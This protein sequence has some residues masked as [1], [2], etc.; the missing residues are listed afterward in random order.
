LPP[1]TTTTLQI[2]PASAHS[3]LPP[4]STISV[5][6]V[7]QDNGNESEGPVLVS[8]QVI[9]KSSE[10]GRSR[11]QTTP[12]LS[13]GGAR[14]LNFRAIPLG[15]ITGTF[16]IKVSATAIGTPAVQRTITMVRSPR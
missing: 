2:P 6:V 15:N 5:Q 3:V 7:I 4:T 8:V 11:S 9:P 16:E 10:T 14:Y 12:E 1:V 13:P